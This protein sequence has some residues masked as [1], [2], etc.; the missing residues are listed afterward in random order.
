VIDP[1]DHPVRQAIARYRQTFFGEDVVLMT[2]PIAASLFKV[3]ERALLQADI[4]M[5]DEGLSPEQRR[6][7]A[8]AALF[9]SVDEEAAVLRQ[10]EMEELKQEWLRHPD[11][12]PYRIAEH[13]G[14]EGEPRA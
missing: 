3:L 1:Y 13:L 11:V 10:R 8:T 4:A 14:G 2:D 5:S 12:A 9:G 7:V 6:R